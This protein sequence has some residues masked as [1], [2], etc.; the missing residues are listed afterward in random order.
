MQNSLQLKIFQLSKKLKVNVPLQILT[1]KSYFKKA[2]K[3]GVMTN[4]EFWKKLKHFLTN[5]G[6]FSEDQMSIEINDEQVS[7]EKIP[8]RNF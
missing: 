6:C 3:Y 7:D 1:L 5:K 4:I 2:T 8:H